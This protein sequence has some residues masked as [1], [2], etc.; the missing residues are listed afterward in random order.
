MLAT[1]NLS[2]LAAPLPA[3]PTSSRPRLLRAIFGSATLAGIL[4]GAVGCDKRASGEPAVVRQTSLAGKPTMLFLL[5]GD[6]ADPRLLPVAMTAQGRIAPITLDNTGWRKF[7]ELYF[8]AGAAVPV[9]R[10]GGIVTESRIRR[11]MWSDKEP[12]Y[13]LPACRELHPLAAVTLDSLSG[14]APLVELLA[15]SAPLPIS[16]PRASASEDNL[17]SARVLTARAAQREGIDRVERAELDLTVQAI[18]TGVTGSPTLVGSY[19]ER[20]KGAGRSA[21]QLFVLGDSSTAGYATSLVYVAR[22]TA[23]EFRRLIDHLDLNGDGVD[24]IV[25]EGWRDG[26]DSYLLILQFAAG[27]WKEA[28]RSATS[29]CGDPP[30]DRSGPLG[31]PRRATN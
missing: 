23:P 17:D 21:H 29:W 14:T 26:G 5:F 2:R 30:A 24:E 28:S 18:H 4:T 6:R 7:D 13:K 22:D 9:Y 12:L 11:G 25:L 8:A 27:R 10:D 31:M 20:G 16:A 19:M 15:T 1:P 3:P